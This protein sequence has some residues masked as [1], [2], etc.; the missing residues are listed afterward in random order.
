ME[1][2]NTLSQLQKATHNFIREHDVLANR[3]EY[4]RHRDFVEQ[5]EKYLNEKK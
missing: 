5:R 4:L 1:L 2:R 3:A